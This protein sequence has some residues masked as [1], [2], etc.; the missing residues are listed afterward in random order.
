MPMIPHLNFSNFFGAGGGAAGVDS[1][2][3]TVADFADN[4]TNGILDKYHV[5]REWDNPDATD[6]ND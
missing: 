3:Q 1:M 6:N 2:A 5:S 4:M